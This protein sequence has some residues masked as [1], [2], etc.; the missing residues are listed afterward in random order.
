MKKWMA[1]VLVMALCLTVCSSFA[2]TAAVSEIMG[3]VNGSVW[4]NRLLGIRC[5]FPGWNY[6]SQEEILERVNMSKEMLS[7]DAQALLETSGPVTA[8]IAVSANQLENTNITVNSAGVSEAEF[9]AFG[10]KNILEGVAGEIGPAYDRAGVTGFEYE[11]VDCSFGGRTV[12]C[13][14]MKAVANG[15]QIYQKQ[16]V[17][18]RNN[19]VFYITVSSYLN[20]TTA[21]QLSCYSFID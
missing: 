1:L 11:I 3:T 6:L 2:E 15:V 16:V 8:M 13:L 20:D 10:A 19:Y 5:D 7:E 17:L 21:D 9:E 12:P 4:E 14:N 18:C